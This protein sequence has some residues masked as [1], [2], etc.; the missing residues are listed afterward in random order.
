MPPVRIDRIDA[1]AILRVIRENMHKR[2]GLDRFADRIGRQ[3]RNADPGDRRL[4]QRFAGIGGK[5]PCTSIT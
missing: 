3:T 4:A 2:T 5:I 1:A